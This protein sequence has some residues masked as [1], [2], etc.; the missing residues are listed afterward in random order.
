MTRRIRDGEL[1]GDV[2]FLMEKSTVGVD[3]LG[4]IK[5]QRT[6]AKRTVKKKK[7]DSNRLFL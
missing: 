1:L 7:K 2:L 5:K 3:H 6:N 4:R